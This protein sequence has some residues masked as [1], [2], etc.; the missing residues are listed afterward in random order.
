MDAFFLKNSAW[1][2]QSGNMLKSRKQLTFNVIFFAIRWLVIVIDL[3]Q[4]ALVPR[5]DA[6]GL[7]RL[8]CLLLLCPSSYILLFDLFDWLWG[9]ERQPKSVLF[10]GKRRP[11]EGNQ[12]CI[13]SLSQACRVKPGGARL[14]ATIQWIR[15]IILKISG[16]KIFTGPLNRRDQDALELVHAT[17]QRWD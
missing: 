17:S 6:W 4:R 3:Y 7:S 13:Y 1:F 14:P 15:K 11:V 9:K 10:P 8:L 2:K 16:E 5:D 12:W